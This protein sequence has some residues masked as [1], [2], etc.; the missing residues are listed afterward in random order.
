MQKP[1]Y[2][3]FHKKNVSKRPVLATDDSSESLVLRNPLIK[4]LLESKKEDYV[5]FESSKIDK[6]DFDYPNF[7]LSIEND[8]SYYEELYPAVEFYN[9]RKYD[10]ALEQF[11]K[12][13]SDPARAMKNIICTFHG[14]IGWLLMY[15]TKNKKDKY[16]NFCIACCKYRLGEYSQALDII[17][18]NS[19]EDAVYLKAWCC[20]KLNQHSEAK[21]FFKEV[22]KANPEYMF[23]YKFPYSE[24]DVL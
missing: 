23:K 4:D 12:R 17:K 21:K 7:N 10:I 1:E 22:F 24:R 8:D 15:N 14:P 13:P 18:D 6:Q 9:H 20:Y 5:E 2:P 16:V 11:E 3:S 19:R